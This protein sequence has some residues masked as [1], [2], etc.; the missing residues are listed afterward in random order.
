MRNKS[1]FSAKALYAINKSST[2]KCKFSSLPLLA[3]KFPKS[4]M[5]F[6]EPIITFSS[7]FASLFG[8]TRHQSLVLFHVN[9]Y[10]PSTKAAHWVKVHQISHVVFPTKSQFFIKIWMFFQCHETFQFMRRCTV[11]SFW[12]L[13]WKLTKFLISFF[14]PWVI[15]SKN[16]AS[17]FSVQIF[18]LTTART[19]VYQIPHVIFGI[20]S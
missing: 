15:F 10:V 18:R 11:S 19:K 14:K 7:N 6:L 8:V 20:K 17:P 12:L 3:L 5:S 16:F 13:A 4:L 1:S 2:S 9:L